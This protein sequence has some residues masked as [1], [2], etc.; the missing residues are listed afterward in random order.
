MPRTVHVPFVS[1]SIFDRHP[2]WGYACPVVPLPIACN[3]D[4]LSPQQRRREQE[5]LAS[6]R[7]ARLSVREIGNGYRFDLSGEPALLARVGEFVALE[8]LC[9]P[10]LDFVLE[11]RSGLGPVSLT[12]SG[13]DP[14]ARTFIR[15]AFAGG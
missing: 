14:A 9:C 8:R 1:R 4:A 6:F 2:T 12:V 5:L 11:A 10:F 13:D 3:L 7:S 15:N